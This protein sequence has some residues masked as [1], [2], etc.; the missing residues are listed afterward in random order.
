MR[1]QTIIGLDIGT[2]NIRTVV[3]KYLRNQARP[4]IMGVSSI[5]SFGLRRGIVVDMEEVVTRVSQALTE[6]ERISGI[7]I[8]RAF[9]SIGGAHVLSQPSQGVI[10][11]SRADGE[12]SQED[13]KR[14]IDA[15]KAVNLGQNQEIIHSL[16]LQFT[17]DGQSEIKDPKGMHG[18]RLEAEVLLIEGV[19]PYLKNFVKC[20]HRTGIDIQ[21]L[22]LAPLASSEAVLTPRQKEL[23]VVLLDM[24]GGTTGLCVFE[25]GRLLHGKV[26]PIGGGHI[27]NDIAIGLRVSIDTAE[28][29]KHEFGSALPNEVKKKEEI[30]LAKIDAN[31]EESVSRHY[32]AEIIKARLEEIFSM[33]NKE[34]QSINREKLLPAGVVLVGGGAKMPGIIDLAKEQLRLPAQIGFPQDLRGVID[35]VDD[36]SFA[37]AVGLV[38]WGRDQVESEHRVLPSLDIFSFRGLGGRVKKIFKH[39][40]P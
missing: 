11:V 28:R 32:V 34:L 5:S 17:V 26:L 21:N 16:P 7:P 35:K 9:I 14:A 40:L 29:V 36:P 22:V 38:L 37:C 39:F 33:V 12:I 1:Y 19:S 4:Q 13:V 2:S 25:E 23:G 6:V 30:Q 10:A 18:V 24:G 3:A 27:T 20:I 31:E 8:E 15:A